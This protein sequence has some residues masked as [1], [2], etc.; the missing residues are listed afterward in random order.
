MR[1]S[2]IIVLLTIVFISLV[3]WHVGGRRSAELIPQ[4]AE[5]TRGDG[6]SERGISIT[7]T[8]GSDDAEVELLPL[9]D[10]VSTV[11]TVPIP[12]L[13]RS[14]QIPDRYPNDVSNL[15]EEKIALIKEN[16]T[17]DPSSVQDWIE[18]GA[19]YRS[20]DDLAGAEEVWLYATRLSSSSPTAFANLG[21]L[22]GYYLGDVT[23]AEEYFLRAIA[24]AP[25]QEHLYDL[26][27]SFYRDV[28]GDETKAQD[29]FAKRP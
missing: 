10:P 13:D 12:R 22:Y 17:E 20:I 5:T 4:V 28:L 25:D 14:V 29:I 24:I 1:Q 8:E 6:T 9:S 3:A 7:T 27:G 11:P 21:D 26:A 18:L 2:Y 23:Q 19:L 15:L 16:L